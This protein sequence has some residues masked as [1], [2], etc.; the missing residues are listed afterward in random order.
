MRPLP[1][2]PENQRRS[3]QR[4]GLGAPG[5]G[6]EEGQ[7]Y[8]LLLGGN[9]PGLFLELGAESTDLALGPGSCFPLILRQ[10]GPEHLVLLLQLVGTGDSVSQVSQQPRSARELQGLLLEAHAGCSFT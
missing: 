10:G 3:S 9:E 1:V 5:P 7:T 2:S 4:R 8:H 6:K